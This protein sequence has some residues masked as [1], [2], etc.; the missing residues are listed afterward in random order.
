MIMPDHRLVKL[1]RREIGVGLWEGD[2]DPSL[3]PLLMCNGIGMNMEVLAPLAALLGGRRIIA[4][5]PPGI[6]KSPDPWLPYTAGSV[7]NWIADILDELEVPEA[8][9]LGF[10]WGGA[11]AQQFA[12][13]HKRRVRKLA[14]A[15]IGPGWPVIPGQASVLSYL[16]DPGWIGQLREN[17]RRAAFIGIGEADRLALTPDFLSRLKLPRMRGYF[18]QMSALAAWTSAL[19]LPLLDRPVMVMAGSE[20]QVVPV[21]N[22]R[23]LA[24]LVPR[25]RLEILD[26]AG[27]LLM[28]SHAE[29]VAALLRSF[30]ASDKQVPKHAA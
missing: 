28:F 16:T 14:L 20:D 1:G 27:H 19:A 13:Q 7:A 30:L 22:A 26:G 29:Q 11:I 2:G 17:P 24:A 9:L 21:A 25:A 12:I 8:D 23:L 10:S 4:F 15:A 18:F 5:D 3:T 6:G